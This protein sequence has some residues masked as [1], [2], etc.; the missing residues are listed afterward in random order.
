M[1]E[2][3]RFSKLN[4]IKACPVCGRK[5]ERGYVITPGIRWDKQKHIIAIQRA[6]RLG[7]IPWTHNN[8]PSLKC[9][10]CEVVV[11]DYGSD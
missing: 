2:N 11:L 3:E 5:L 1:N 6:R 9:E 4:S 7:S 10:T 8:F